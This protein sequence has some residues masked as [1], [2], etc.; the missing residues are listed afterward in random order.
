MR[1]QLAK[2]AA[3]GYGAKHQAQRAALT[4]LVAAGG[5]TCWGCGQP[6]PPGHPRDLGH[7]DEDRTIYRGPE[8]RGPCNRAAGA[9]RAAAVT[10]AK[11]RAVHL[12]GRRPATAT[13]W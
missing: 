9:R 11:R 8:H 7:D 4:P 3:R 13:R 10:N 1:R 12:A 2:T 6:L 5:V